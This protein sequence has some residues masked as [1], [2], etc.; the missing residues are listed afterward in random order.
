MLSEKLDKI[1]V[2]FL[3]F[4]LAVLLVRYL[5]GCQ[6]P[7]TTSI[8]EAEE[9][10]QEAFFYAPSSV[11]TV[12]SSP[13]AN[14][15][16]ADQCDRLVWLMTPSGPQLSKQLPSWLR[17]AEQRRKQQEWLRGMIGIVADELG[18]DPLAAEMVWRKAILESSG[19]PG[20]VH[21]LSADLAANRAAAKRGRSASTERWAMAVV[22]TFVRRNGKLRE[23]GQYDAWRL[24]RGLYGQVTGLHLRRWGADVPPWSLC[25][26]V[27]ATVTVFWSMRA[28][29]VE[30]HGTTLRDAYRRFSSGRCAERSAEREA[31]FDRLAR[32]R[33][34]GLKLKRFDP[35]GKAKLGGNWDESVADRSVLLARLRSRIAVELG[36]F[37]VEN[38]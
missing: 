26:E 33:V 30:C 5:V 9:S 17:D 14:L 34:R 2:I 29:L 12:A 28:G 36:P 15:D 13:R 8:I 10:K 23:V 31:G 3:S 27:I 4:V 24:G 37:P 1:M 21:I 19:N 35:D 6:M 22:P 18:A 38:R 20:A 16:V 32:G 7:E 25:D 11:R